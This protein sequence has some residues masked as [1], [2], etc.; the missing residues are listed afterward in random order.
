[1][2]KASHCSL[3]VCPKPS[4]EPNSWREASN[5]STQHVRPLLE[6]LEN[7]SKGSHG[8]PLAP[9]PVPHIQNG[10]SLLPSPSSPSVHRRQQAFLTSRAWLLGWL[11]VYNL[12]SCV[13]TASFLKHTRISAP[14]EGLLCYQVDPVAL[15]CVS[16]ELPKLVQTLPHCAKAV[17]LPGLWV[18]KDQNQIPHSALLPTYTGEGERQV[19]PSVAQAGSDLIV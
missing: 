3:L 19:S 5:I 13:H 4:A 8:L 12:P 18:L 17:Y 9:H 2:V 6:F 1:M 11:F 7:V 14:R 16:V 10:Y 15:S